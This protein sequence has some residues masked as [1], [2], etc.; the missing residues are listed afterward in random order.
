ML[1]GFVVPSNFTSSLLQAGVDQATAGR[2]T[3][4]LNREV[5]IPIRDQVRRTGAQASV[6]SRPPPPATPVMQVTARQEQVQRSAPIQNP[7]TSTPS[8]NLARPDALTPT[9]AQHIEARTMQHDM[10]LVQAGLVPTP[11]PSQM[12]P[13][14]SFQT[15]SVPFNMA[16]QAP[17][18]PVKMPVDQQGTAVP[19]A[20]PR[21]LPPPTPVQTTPSTPIVKDYA[22]DPYRESI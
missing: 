8:F 16:P 20:P 12:T 10:E 21:Q 3:A 18:A 7:I 9:P 17:V 6:A 14:R 5:F 15:A 1:L 22:Q 11:H 2:L 19:S 13:A 4:D